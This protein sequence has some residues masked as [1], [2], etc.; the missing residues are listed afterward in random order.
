[1]EN[2]LQIDFKGL[3]S[4]LPIGV[5]Q[6][7][8]NGNFQYC[9]EGAAEILGYESSEEL[10]K[11][12]IKDLY[13][14]SDHRNELLAL[15]RK[16]RGEL[17]C[18]IQWKRKDDTEILVSDFARFIYENEKEIGVQ[19]AFIDS[20]YKKLFNRL[21]SGFFRIK[22]DLRTV[23][24]VN[25]A[26]ARI[27]GYDSPKEM[28]KIDVKILYKDPKDY[29]TLIKE[30][31][32]NGEVTNYRL[33]MK[34][35]DEKTITI[36]VNC[37]LIKDHKGRTLGREGTFTD[38]TEQD[39]FRQLSEQ[40]LGVYQVELEDGKPIIVY[41]NKVFAKMFEYSNDELMGMNIEE[42]Y[43]NRE[44]VDKFNRK[45][46]QNDKKGKPVYA[47]PLE[48]LKKDGERF[49][50]EIF[51]YAIKDE[52]DNIVGR[53]GIV[54]DTT[55]KVLLEKFLKTRSDVE[56]FVHGFI[57]SLIGIDSISQVILEEMEEKV[58]RKYS[59][60]EMEY[61]KELSRNILDTYEKIEEESKKLIDN[62]KQ[63]TT[64]CENIGIL[65][66]ERNL[67]KK[68][69]ENL[70]NELK[71]NI[72][73]R[74]I[75]IRE[76]QRRIRNTFQR[77]QTEIRSNKEMPSARNLSDNIRFSEVDLDELDY[78]YLLSRVKHLR[79]NLAI[80]C[81]DVEGLRQYFLRSE[82][83]KEKL[84]FQK[85]NVLNIVNDIIDMY[86]TDALLKGIVIRK[87]K[88]TIPEIEVAPTL[89]ERAISNIIQNA[90]KYSFER[91]SYITVEVENLRKEIKIK[92]VDYGVGILPN[93][94]KSG[95]IFEFG[96]RG[97]F[98]YDRNR[99]GSGIGLAEANRIIKG[100]KG[101][102]KIKSVP[103]VNDGTLI[104]MET[105]HVTEVS[106]F[107]PHKVSGG[108]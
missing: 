86:Q 49:W 82:N 51:C 30:L 44:D 19:G 88:K 67:L 27:F 68:L 18:D 54:M 20:S 76:L 1:M 106:V 16:E 26:V 55:D 57:T 97:K 81:Y 17:N 108:I 12:N 42:L 61:V 4:N 23:L 24:E 2:F 37:K 5:Y 99:T 65:K 15:M 21:N 58:E 62:V 77:M 38:I 22:K 84:V 50:I 33:Q 43:A 73:E 59:Q 39:K 11:R 25:E 13:I 7:D 3:I 96:T 29:D 34:R 83:I 28:E 45:L 36:S 72:A 46:K 98:S 100:H 32:K 9:N 48:V 75:E 103:A 14:D 74:I 60:P 78:L 70:R 6:V 56:R 66:Y 52:E 47:F 105:P 104:T 80:S 53:K 89:F 40:P 64:E 63:I 8:E 95:R 79:N 94:I 85:T 35:K 69:R 31:K 102:I 107:L 90:V 93:E 92:V 71:L 87:P 41:C 91:R 10:R 101:R